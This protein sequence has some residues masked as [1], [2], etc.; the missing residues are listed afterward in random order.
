[1]KGSKPNILVTGGAGYIGSHTV[2]SLIENG[3]HP[4]ILDDLRN[5]D[6][7]AVQ[8]L[9]HLTGQELD[10]FDTNCQDKKT[11]NNIFKKY[12]VA[13]VIHFAAD[14]AVG[15]SV[16]QPLK[17]FN[18]NI[19]ALVNVLEVM[20]E[21]QKNNF[22]FSSSCT[23]YGEPKEIPVVEESPLSYSSP[24]GYT[25]LVGEQML[26]Q[27]KQYKPHFKYV[28][29]RYFNPIGAHESGSIGEVP[30]G[31]PNNLLPYI[32]QTAAGERSF[33][34][35]F[36]DDYDTPDGTCVRDYIHVMDLAEAHV[37]ALDYLL[38]NKEGIENEFNIGTG[39]GTSVKEL[40]DIFIE[41]CNIDL[42]FKIGDRR[43]GDVPMI[44][45][46]TDKAKKIL[47]WQ[48]KRTI[49]QAV[50]SAWRFEQKM[51]KNEI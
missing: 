23:V 39:K 42:P 33:L 28:A 7:Q 47:N 25:K 43:K 22:V 9:T 32:S 37:A 8:R 26:A 4:I 45:A 35:V 6:Q 31:V 1:M 19:S 51:K 10:F 46:K 48:A 24:Y 3:Y 17:Y 21:Q 5:T 36:G 13:G 38:K 34:T 12:D 16:D 15:E 20:E 11:L 14:K 2:V 30:S 29:L 44:Y 49:S 41:T 18:N 40:I 50:S 27:Y